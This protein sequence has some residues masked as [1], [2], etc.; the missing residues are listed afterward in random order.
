MRLIREW[1]FDWTTR[2]AGRLMRAIGPRLHG[3]RIARANLKIAFP[4]KSDREIEDLLR[5]VWDNLGRVMAEYAF[6]D[7]LYACDTLDPQQKR[8]VIDPETIER[9]KVL[10]SARQPLLVFA[11]HIANWE[12]PPLLA[13]AF[14]VDLTAVYRPSDNRQH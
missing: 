1:D 12:L 14:A 3:H 6:L 10:A 2:A 4:D 9:V 8:I 7:R 5:G 13:L 11:A